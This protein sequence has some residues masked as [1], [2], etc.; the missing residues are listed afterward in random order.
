LAAISNRTELLEPGGCLPDELLD[1][2]SETIAVLDADR[3]VVGDELVPPA[4][5]ADRRAGTSLAGQHPQ[6]GDPAEG[7]LVFEPM[8][9][10]G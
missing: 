5:P 6:V 1:P 2:G 10:I 7:V 8:M 4:V 9:C 3:R